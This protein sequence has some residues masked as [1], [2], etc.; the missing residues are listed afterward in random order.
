L[1]PVGDILSRVGV[2]PTLVHDVA[3]GHLGGGDM[4]VLDAVSEARPPFNPEQA[5]AQCAALLRKYNITTLVG[6]HYAGGWPVARFREHGV[7]YIQSSRAKSALYQDLLPFLNAGRVELLNNPRLTAQLC[8][9]ERR[10]ARSGKDSIDHIPGGHDDLANAVAGVLVGLDL[11][12]RPAL[13]NLKAVTGG[14]GKGVAV[15]DW[16][17]GAFLT[18]VDEGSD[19]ASI[20]CG[21]RKNADNTLTFGY[22]VLDADVEHFRP[23]L[24][25]EL[26]RRLGACP[27]TGKGIFAPERLRAPFERLGCYVVTPPP[28]FDPEDHLT[29]AAEYLGRGEVRFCAPVAAKMKS[30][31]I[32][33][34]LTLRAGDKVE[35]ALQGAFI[36]ALWA[37]CSPP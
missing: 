5:T 4:C 29:S 18:V 33:S 35:T 13:V 12:R 20:L 32:G 19:I 2:D 23:G 21:V 16:Y 9:L 14:E 17:A 37:M 10:T 3:I 25:G 15:R 36:S 11:D 30:K 34:A 28:D 8:G 7:E 22:D 1:T 31:P 6:D 24:Y 27:A 26:V